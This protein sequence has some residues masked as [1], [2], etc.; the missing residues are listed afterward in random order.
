[1]VKFA[2]TY[3]AMAQKVDIKYQ[4]LQLRAKYN[5]LKEKYDFVQKYVGR[6]EV[7]V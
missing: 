1:M 3:Y 4:L 5:G 7:L 6:F 2:Y